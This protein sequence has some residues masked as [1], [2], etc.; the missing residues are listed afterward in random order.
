VIAFSH[1]LGL[2]ISNKVRYMAL[3]FNFIIVIG[4]LKEF[5]IKIAPML[6]KF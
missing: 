5:K 3:I 1:I 4:H 6:S 2:A